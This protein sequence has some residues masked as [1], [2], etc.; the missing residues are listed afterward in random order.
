MSLAD[1]HKVITALD[2]ELNTGYST[3][4]EGNS[5]IDQRKVI[6]EL[7]KREGCFVYGR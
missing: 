6:N 1:I 5:Y 4:T 3:Q 2:Q 7:F